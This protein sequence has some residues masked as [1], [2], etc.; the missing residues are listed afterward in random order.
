MDYLRFILERVGDYLDVRDQF[1]LTTLT[2][3]L[4]A[5]LRFDYIKID[6]PEQTRLLLKSPDNWVNAR[7]LHIFA[8]FHSALNTAYLPNLQRLFIYKHANLTFPYFSR[9][10]QHVKELYI[11]FYMINEDDI[12]PFN[13]PNLR[14]LYCKEIEIEQLALARIAPQLHELHMINCRYFYLDQDGYV[15]ESVSDMKCVVGDHDTIP[16]T[17]I[18]EKNWPKRENSRSILQ[19]RYAD[20]SHDLEYPLIPY[21]ETADENLETQLREFMLFYPPLEKVDDDA[22]LI[23]EQR[24]STESE[25]SWEVNEEEFDYLLEEEYWLP[26]DGQPSD[27]PAD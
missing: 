3:Y 7:E 13:F 14:F 23:S 22:E 17:Y 9:L 15:V 16:K 20:H 25:R 18:N 2:R 11:L 6:K 19:K 8:A 12:T 5:K 24:G 21:L 4:R 26:E 27:E 1:I 10:F